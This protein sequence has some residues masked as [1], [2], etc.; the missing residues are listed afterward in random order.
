M[1]VITIA[2]GAS[3]GVAQSA[4]ALED[5]SFKCVPKTQDFRDAYGNHQRYEYKGAVYS[6]G[7]GYYQYHHWIYPFDKGTFTC[8][9][10]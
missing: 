4:T 1:A 2:L 5:G 3:L 7:H 6:A 8:Q 9:A 10:G